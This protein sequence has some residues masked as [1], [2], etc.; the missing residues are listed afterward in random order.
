M[1]AFRAMGPGRNPSRCNE[2]P[3]Q[4]LNTRVTVRQLLGWIDGPVEENW[5]PYHLLEANCQHFAADLQ[6]YLKEPSTAFHRSGAAVQ[7]P[8]QLLQDR[9]AIIAN[10]A[11]NPR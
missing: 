11:Q 8:V 1:K 3:Y 10:I 6:A 4:A 2:E 5:R 9:K 7:V